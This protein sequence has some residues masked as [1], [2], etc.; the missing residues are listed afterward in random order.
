MLFSNTKYD[1]LTA[2][3]C[4]IAADVWVG[5]YAQ[6]L[7]AVVIGNGAVIGAGPIVTQH[8]PP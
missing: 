5:S 1:D 6:I 8:V 3:K 7:R 4:E 2:K